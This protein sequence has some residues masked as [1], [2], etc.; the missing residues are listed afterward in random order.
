MIFIMIFM[1]KSAFS[2]YFSQLDREKKPSNKFHASVVTFFSADH[3]QKHKAIAQEQCAMGKPWEN[4]R[5]NGGSL[6][7]FMIFMDE[8]PNLVMIKNVGPP[9]HS[10]QL[11]NITTINSGLW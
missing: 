6:G 11:V 3:R 5:K 10:V 2:P 4:H 8:I 1:A 7:D 9:F